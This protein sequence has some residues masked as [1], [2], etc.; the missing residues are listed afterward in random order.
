[1]STHIL[2]E[3][4]A[5]ATRVLLIHKGKL[6]AQG[7]TDEIRAMRSG[8]TVDLVVRG[9]VEVVRAALAKQD[10]VL[11]VTLLAQTDATRLRLSFREGLDDAGRADVVE[12][13]V[14]A[15]VGAGLGVRE[16][17]P[18][19]GSLED[20]FAALTAEDSTHDSTGGNRP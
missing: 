3:V 14:G 5:C 4:E 16:V 13:C 20:V 6:V 11:D 7:G 19:S 15:V 17:R 10:G 12:R 1:V 8:A 18:S 9:N 2:S